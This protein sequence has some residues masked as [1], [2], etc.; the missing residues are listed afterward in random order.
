VFI[1][2]NILKWLNKTDVISTLGG[3][4]QFAE[5]SVDPSRH[6]T[7]QHSPDQNSASI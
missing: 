5:L 3:C 6:P 2:K 4:G 7:L 1:N